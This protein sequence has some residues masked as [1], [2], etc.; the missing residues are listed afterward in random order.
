MSNPPPTGHSSPTARLLEALATDGARPLV[1][2]YDD[3]TGER[4]EL[5]VVTFE[6][7]VAKTANLMVDGLGLDT[8]SRVALLLP[9]H[10]QTAV[11]VAA[12]W[13]VGASA[14]LAEPA[15]A[16]GADAARGADLAVTGPDGLETA[17]A[18]DEVVALSLRP[19]GGRFADPLPAGVVDYAVEVP[20]HGDRFAARGSVPEVLD[21]EGT[22]LTGGAVLDLAGRLA[23]RWGLDEGGRLLTALDPATVDGAMALLPAALARGGSVVLQR[24]ADPAAQERRVADEKVTATAG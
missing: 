4:V 11:W 17:L 9:T 5:S 20:G 16:S 8:G 15:A 7:W 23:D 1:T 12:C 10:W 18:A 21:V 24:H 14:V 3:A 2:F 13:R 19:L 6:N 22:V